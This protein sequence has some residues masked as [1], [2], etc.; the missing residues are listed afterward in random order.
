VASASS[1]ESCAAAGRAGYH[2]Q[3]VPTIVSHDVVVKMLDAYR[4]AWVEAGHE[5]GAA[6]I[7]VKYNCYISE[8]RTEVL[9]R[10]EELEKNHVVLMSEACA[11]WTQIRS[12]QYQGYEKLVEKARDHDFGLA[13]RDGKILAGT[14]DDV[15]KQ[16][17][18]VRDEFGDD[19]CV[20][21]QVNS[22]Y[23]AYRDADRTLRLFGE[24]VAPL[25]K[26]RE[27]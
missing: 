11:A 17:D 4:R 1:P 14:P 20:S 6:R 8:D 23:T 19:L 21:I 9:R 5:P 18:T 27:R 16:L 12:D 15:V 25:F 2:L 26:P 22:G 10:A 13:M 7:Q 3:V 24:K